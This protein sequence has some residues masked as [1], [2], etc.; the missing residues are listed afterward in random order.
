MPTEEKKLK[1]V[2]EDAT[3]LLRVEDLQ[4]SFDKPGRKRIPEEAS[5][6]IVSGLDFE[7]HREETFGIAGESGCGKSITA[8]AVMGLLP[9]SAVS[10]GRLYFQPSGRE[11]LD[12]LRLDEESKRLL[13]GKEMGMIFQEPMTSLNPVFSIGYQ[14]SETLMIHKGLNR[15]EALKESVE[16]LRAVKIPSP[17]LRVKDYPHQLSGGMRQRVMTA[18]AVACKPSLLIA[19]EPTTALDVTIQAEILSL[20]QE[21]KEEMGMSIILITHDLGIVAHNVD[22][23]AIMYA[24]RIVEIAEVSSLF[25]RPA[26]PYTIGLIESL[27]VEKKHQLKPIPGTVPS[28]ENLP[29]GCK[30]STRCSFRVDECEVA[31]PPLRRLA[32]EPD[33]ALQ[34]D[35]HLVRCINA[36]EI[37]NR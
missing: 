9:P 7:I 12:L 13:R 14:I 6:N 22:R 20:L 24:G 36:E 8:L 30:F 33:S 37:I 1:S 28:P 35:N 16:L 17:E 31:E 25:K 34:G 11:R 4:I 23:A 27:P 15:K 21:I 19:D 29:S 5:L 26:H 10:S 3:P 18:M 2:N 32:F